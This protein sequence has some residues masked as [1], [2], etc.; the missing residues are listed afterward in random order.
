MIKTLKFEIAEKFVPIEVMKELNEWKCLATSKEN[1]LIAANDLINA[2]KTVGDDLAALK[3]KS[4]G[5][6]AELQSKI[7]R[8]E[9][10][11]S[12]IRERNKQ[13]DIQV[14]DLAKKLAEAMKELIEWKCLA[15]S[16]ENE[17][18]AANDTIG[19]NKTLEHDITK[20]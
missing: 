16:R 10:V 6:E 19:A 14:D 4:A 8:L 12:E 7:L 18:I 11:N 2:N 13:S 15:T 9:K 17:L 5:I 3:K 20:K 1:E